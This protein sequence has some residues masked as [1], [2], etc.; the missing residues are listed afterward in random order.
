MAMHRAASLT[1]QPKAVCLRDSIAIGDAGAGS[2]LLSGE[3]LRKN[4]I[5]GKTRAPNSNGRY[6]DPLPQVR[7]GCAHWSRGRKR[8]GSAAERQI[9]L[10]TD[11]ASGATNFWADSSLLITVPGSARPIHYPGKFCS[12]QHHGTGY[13]LAPA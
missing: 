3:L 8:T 5:R 1:R 6:F 11:P 9:H 2:D 4:A 10:F 7:E 13:D 12:N